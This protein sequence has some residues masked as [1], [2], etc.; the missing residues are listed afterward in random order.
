MLLIVEDAT[1]YFVYL[2]ASVLC[3]RY[4][5]RDNI[6]ITNFIEKYMFIIIF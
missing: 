3:T 1:I 6:E 5:S 4:V 2:V